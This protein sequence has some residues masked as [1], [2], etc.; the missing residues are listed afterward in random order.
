MS[1]RKV[2]KVEKIKETSENLRG[3]VEEELSNDEPNFSKESYQ[4]LKFHG[5]YQQDDR[6]KRRG[7]DKHWTYM[8]RGRVPGGKM[9]AQQF[10]AVDTIVEEYGDKT[11]RIT[12]RQAFQIYG[13]IKGNLKQTF[14]EINN[15]MITT[16]GACGEIGRASCRERG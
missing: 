6:D 7:R 11:L 10:L 1:R 3:S 14:R 5:T 13:V 4:I 16:M 8:I 12:T 2:S 15:A 9:T